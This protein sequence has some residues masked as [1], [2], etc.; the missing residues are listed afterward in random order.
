[1]LEAASSQEN[2]KRELGK[3]LFNHRFGGPVVARHG[4]RFWNAQ[5]APAST[6]GLFLGLAN[7]PAQ[8]PGKERTSLKDLAEFQR[9]LPLGY[10]IPL[11]AVVVFC[12]RFGPDRRCGKP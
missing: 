2:V 11:H 3:V 8:R 12:L 5:A 9:L 7:V 1:M 10:G 6:P 4:S